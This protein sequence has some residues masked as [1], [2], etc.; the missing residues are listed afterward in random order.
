MSKDR[1]TM[2]AI[3]CPD[4]HPLSVSTDKLTRYMMGDEKELL[5]SCERCDE[6]DTYAVQLL[7]V[8]A[9]WEIQSEIEETEAHLDYAVDDLKKKMGKLKKKL[10]G[11]VKYLDE[12]ES[13][14]TDVK[15]EAGYVLEYLEKMSIL[16]RLQEKKGW[17]IS[18]PQSV[19]TKEW[20]MNKPCYK[21]GSNKHTEVECNSS[22]TS[23]EKSE[24]K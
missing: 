6:S 20:E 18:K 23:S 9:G 10:S 19:L 2:K 24:T 5:A 22:T 4:G 14:A 15:W 16:L 12:V 3:K 8:P 1:V 11:K 17:F 13:A 7:S 21:C